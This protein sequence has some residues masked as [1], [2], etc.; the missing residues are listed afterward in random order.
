MGLSSAGVGDCSRIQRLCR[1][2]WAVHAGPLI[3]AFAASTLPA[4]RV[5]VAGFAEPTR[6]CEWAGTS[7]I[8]SV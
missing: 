1:R 6:L 5:L 2:A 7:P 3:A 8:T 4:G